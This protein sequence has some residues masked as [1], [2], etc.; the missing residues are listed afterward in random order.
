MTLL[1]FVETTL[2]RIKIGMI[3]IP[4]THYR[5]PVV[6]VTAAWPRLG[7]RSFAFVRILCRN[8]GLE[9]PSRIGLGACSV[10]L[11][12][13]GERYRTVAAKARFLACIVHAS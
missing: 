8:N 4:M 7:P 9:P 6:D 3:P 2:G 5:A 12:V 11:C 10:K 1:S 13:V